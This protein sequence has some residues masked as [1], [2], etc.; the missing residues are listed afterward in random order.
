MLE[1]IRLLIE[2]EYAAQKSDEWLKLRGKMLTASDAAT[3]TGGNPYS[4]ESE[5]ILNKCGHRTFFGNEA[6][7]H[8]EKYEDEARDKWCAMTGEV[9]HEIGLFPHPRYNWLGGSPDGITES[10]KL[11]EI[12]CPLKRKITPD[13]PHHYMPQLQLLM[14][15]LDLDEAVFIQYKPQE[16][17]WPAPEEFVVTH[18]PRDPEWMTVNVPKMRHLWDKV[19]WHRVNG[20]QYLLDAKS[21]PKTKRVRSR[22]VEKGWSDTFS[23]QANSED[24]GYVSSEG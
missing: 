18:V 8:G 21:A 5:F 20:V 19:L 9:S 17:T 24:D 13:V 12:K 14:D 16:L 6:T 4:S 2:R 1:K 15:I 22:Q 3:A 11:V 23:I 7:Q 10:G